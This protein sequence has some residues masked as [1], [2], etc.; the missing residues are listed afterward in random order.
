MVKP[1]ERRVENETPPTSWR[2]LSLLII[3]VLFFAYETFDD[4]V[5]IVNGKFKLKPARVEQIEK[6]LSDMDENSEQYVLIANEDN[7][8]MCK[9]CLRGSFFLLKGEVWKVGVTSRGSS[10]RYPKD[11]L[12]RMGLTYVVEFKGSLSE[13]LKKEKIRITKY[14]LSEE[15]LK[16]PNYSLETQQRYRLARPPG[17][18]KDS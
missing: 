14:P 3:L 8:Y 11:E 7:H 9:H 13:C 12:I 17:N 10:L 16:R 18:M 5:H 2:K 4:F 6:Q 15:N 1:I